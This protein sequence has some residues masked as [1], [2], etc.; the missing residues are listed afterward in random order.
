MLYQQIYSIFVD[1][2]TFASKNITSPK[3]PIHHFPQELLGNRE[4]GGVA[5]YGVDVAVGAFGCRF[6]VGDVVRDFGRRE[7]L[8]AAKT[9]TKL[10]LL[11]LLLVAEAAIVSLAKDSVCH[12]P[13]LR[14]LSRLLEF[15]IR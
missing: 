3:P 8:A 5:Y 1:L 11:Q 13:M 7:D 4:A 10:R 9:A 12:I 14:M 6:F 15:V 2:Q